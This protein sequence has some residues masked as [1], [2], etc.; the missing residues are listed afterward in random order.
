MFKDDLKIHLFFF[1]TD[2]ILGL[3]AI[4]INFSRLCNLVVIQQFEVIH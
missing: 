3:L 1:W 4:F 2:T